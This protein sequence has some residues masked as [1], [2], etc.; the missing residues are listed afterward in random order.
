MDLKRMRFL[1]QGQRR[2]R[3]ALKSLR[4]LSH[5]FNRTSYSYTDDEAARIR[6]VCLEEIERMEKMTAPRE[7]RPEPPY[8]TFEL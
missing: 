3:A 2:T 4:W 5:C 1:S 6:Q 7:P 8:E